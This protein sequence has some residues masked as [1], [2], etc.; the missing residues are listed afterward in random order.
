MTPQDVRKTME[1]IDSLGKQVLPVGDAVELPP[2]SG[3]QQWDM[4]EQLAGPN[5]GDER[6]AL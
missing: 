4:A 2:D 5:V 6:R 3:W 1:L